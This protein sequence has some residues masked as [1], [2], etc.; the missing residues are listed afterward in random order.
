MQ[1]R[2]Y[3]RKA[4]TVAGVLRGALVGIGALTLIGCGT[5]QDFAGSPIGATT[6]TEAAPTT[7][8]PTSTTTT[9]TTTTTTPPAVP[10]APK[11]TPKPP[12]PKPLAPKPPAPKPPAPKPPAPACD[13]NYTPCVPIDSDV[14][15]AGGS[16]DGPSYV[17]GPV[18]VIG[19]DI[20]RLDADH[21]GIG[22]E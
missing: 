10:P 12:A 6:T 4:L 19:R 16:G 2:F 20:Y 11:V 9:T 3:A 18:R 17:V 22:C 13:P 7:T 1:A 5:G 8:T 15:C 14:D 21:D